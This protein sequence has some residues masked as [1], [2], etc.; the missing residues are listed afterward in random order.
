MVL[1]IDISTSI[2]GFAIVADEQLVYYDSVDLRKFKDV[3]DK[4]IA[5]KEKLLD[6]YEKS[7]SVYI[8][9]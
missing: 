2:T 8:Y 3:F 6:L 9:Y 4:T 5:L 7:M 1:G